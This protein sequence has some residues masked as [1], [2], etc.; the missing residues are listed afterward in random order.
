M[1]AHP[2][3]D[4]EFLASLIRRADRIVALTG[5]GL[6]TAAGIPD[7]RGPQGLYVTRRYDPEKTFEIDWFLRQPDYFY[8]FAADFIAL[9]ARIRPT[10][11]HYFLAAL[12]QTGKLAAVVTQNIDMLHQ[13]A[14]NRRVIEIHGSPASATCCSCCEQLT[15]LD[16]CWWQQ[17]M[18]QNPGT[19]VVRCSDCAGLLK[20]DIVFYGE[21]VQ[22][23]AT[24]EAAVADCDLLLVLGTS[25]TVYPAALL[26]EATTAPVIAVSQGDIAL[27]PAP[28]RYRF[29]T[30]LDHFCRTMAKHLNLTVVTD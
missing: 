14:G 2:N 16:L 13:T 24:A 7:F 1:M 22:R 23:M 20:P 29:N 27:D 10:F 28:H 25:L 3:S 30:D 15:A 17:A 8:A 11:S 5:A 12:E 4:A 18:T 21:P 9:L 19:Q 6:S 26:P